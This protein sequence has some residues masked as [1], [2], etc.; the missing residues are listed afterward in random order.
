MIFSRLHF[1]L[2]TYTSSL[3]AFYTH[4]C[5][6]SQLSHLLVLGPYFLYKAVEFLEKSHNFCGIWTGNICSTFQTIPPC[7]LVS[8]RVTQAVTTLTRQLVATSTHL[9]PQHHLEPTP[10]RE[11]NLPFYPYRK[12]KF[13]PD[14]AWQCFNSIK[15]Y[16]EGSTC[17]KLS[18]EYNCSIT[19]IRKKS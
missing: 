4:A 18:S 13:I 9:G 1:L 8:S 2:I 7:C 12:S 10:C 16:E 15:K 17:R 3:G 5:P 14:T 19:Q 11:L 6:F